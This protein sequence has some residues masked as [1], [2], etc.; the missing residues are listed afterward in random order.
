M[1]SYWVNFITNGNPNG[2]GLPEWPSFSESPGNIM[3]LGDKME[4]RPITSQQ[5]FETLL[6]MMQDTE[7]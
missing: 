7:R 6:K 5:K 3:E 2:E 4:P 1:S